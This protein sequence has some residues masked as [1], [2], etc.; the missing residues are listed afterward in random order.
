MSDL[1][2]HR[3]RQEHMATF[4][5]L[6]IAHEN[7]TYA[8]QA[9]QAAF[10]I[11]ARLEALLSRY[12]DD[13]EV[14]QIRALPVGETLRVNPDTFHCLQLAAQMQAATGGAFDPG[15]G[16]QMDIQR[17]DSAATGETPR[18]R[19]VM[20]PQRFTVSI[21]D[22]TVALDLGA[23]GKGFTL[24]RMAEELQNW[25]I[26]RALLIAGDSSILALDGPA[27]DAA[28]W[29]ISLSPAKKLS[30]QRLA[31]GASGTTVK[32]LHI[33]DPRTG[34]PAAGPF[35]TWAVHPS[36]AIADALSTAWM[37]LAP[38]EIDHVCRALPG[39]QAILQLRGHDSSQLS[40]FGPYE[41]EHPHA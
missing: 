37:L 35:R 8:R 4:F 32:G 41:E 39:S 9:A 18:G 1:P 3:H 36:A 19:L 30:L 14:T 24:D 11:T 12:R 22:G 2:I 33:L 27:P 26:T 25:D 38:E 28:G 34:Q 23:I 17:G 15:L 7:E 16:A 21:I 6:R 5:E 31:V 10:A 13:S 40:I 29:E 20:D